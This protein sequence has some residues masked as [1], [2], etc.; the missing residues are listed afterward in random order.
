MTMTCDPDNEQATPE[1]DRAS[2]T[3][4]RRTM[5]PISMMGAMH[6]ALRETGFKAWLCSLQ[7][8][9]LQPVSGLVDAER[10]Y[11]VHPADLDRIVSTYRDL[12]EGPVQFELECRIGDAHDSYYRTH[13]WFGS[14]LGNSRLD[15]RA[16][17]VERQ[18]SAPRPDSDGP[19]ARGGGQDLDEE[20]EADTVEFIAHRLRSPITAITGNAHIL[21]Y[22][23]DRLTGRQRAQALSD[24]IDA[25]DRLCQLLDDL[26]M[27]TGPAR[28]ASTRSQISS[29]ALDDVLVEVV[30][31]H[32]L[33]DP[34]RPIRIELPPQV[35]EAF[36]HIRYV[37]EI[38][39][40]L[41]EHARNDSPGDAPIAVTIDFDAKAVRVHVLC[42][43][44][45]MDLRD[46]N[47]AFTTFARVPR[48][49]A[50]SDGTGIGFA[51]CRRLARAQGG[52][53]SA[54]SHGDGASEFVLALRR[55]PEAPIVADAGGGDDYSAIA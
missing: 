8:G 50:L 17:V 45:R 37:D 3:P 12:R 21:R 24:L 6:V 44:V 38:L 34:A 5:R 19:D 32:R 18:A 55:V 23:A 43:R 20:Q 7:D 40:S 48:A 52:S 53:I 2:K 46:T 14:V 15:E 51:V 39:D 10:G 36:G 25:T 35:P 42:Q 31:R 9:G 4:R 11:H 1:S 49:T 13:C 30:K 29:L 41:L 33:P 27:L 16:I 26:T 22:G 47:G 28:L 54:R